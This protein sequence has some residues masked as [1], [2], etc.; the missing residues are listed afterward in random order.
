MRIIDKRIQK[1]KK[2]T[3]VHFNTQDKTQLNT[4]LQRLKWKTKLHRLQVNCG[5]MLP[6]SGMASS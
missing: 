5:C 3:T 2:I 1:N 4:T 6:W